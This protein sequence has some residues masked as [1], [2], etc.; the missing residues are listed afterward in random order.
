MEGFDG[1][2]HRGLWADRSDE[3]CS[4]CHLRCF[5]APGYSVRESG[6]LALARQVMLAEELVP[7]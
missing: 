5:D 7:H 4:N 6:I 2:E 1:V 3:R